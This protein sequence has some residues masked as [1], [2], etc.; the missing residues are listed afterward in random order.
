ME[1]WDHVMVVVERPVVERRDGNA[2]VSEPMSRPVSRYWSEDV[3]PDCQEIRGR[4][5]GG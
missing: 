3:T 5:A 2:D 4:Y 1:S